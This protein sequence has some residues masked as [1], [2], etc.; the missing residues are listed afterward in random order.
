MLAEQLIERRRAFHKKI[1]ERA[2]YVPQSEEI[3]IS[4]RLERIKAERFGNDPEERRPWRCPV[5]P[6]SP[7]EWR[8]WAIAARNRYHY[9]RAS[10]ADI[11]REV[12]EVWGLTVS[13]LVSDNR[14]KKYVRARGVAF[15]LAYRC[16]RFSLPQLGKEFGGRDHTTILHAVHEAP[17]RLMIPEVNEKARAAIAKLDLSAEKRAQLIAAL[18]GEAPVLPEARR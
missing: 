8:T 11:R 6:P 9:R 10:V 18:D 1:A 14:T 3:D 5:R 7:E 4:G 17:R 2:R 13:E 16:T 12:A 15:W